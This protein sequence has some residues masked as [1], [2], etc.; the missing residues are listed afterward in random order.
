MIT[1]SYKITVELLFD[2]EQNRFI[3]YQISVLPPRYVLLER[4]TF[5]S[6]FT[7]ALLIPYFPLAKLLLGSYFV[8]E[9]T[10]WIMLE[11]MVFIGCVFSATY[12]LLISCM[13]KD[14][15]RLSQFWVRINQPLLIL[16][17]FWVPRYII[18][19][20]S[21][22]LGFLCYLN[23]YMYITEG[24][25]RAVLATDQF[26]PFWLCSLMLTLWISICLCA[27]FY[28]FRQRTDHL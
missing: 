10:S 21:P 28:Y 1:L 22:F 11:S 15:S 12:N 16:G 8:T 24:L 3:D 5:A 2:L 6:L 4:I 7:F 9:R 23:P 26:L 25:R 20:Y 14:S 27:S 18:A 17:G 13:L 19:Q